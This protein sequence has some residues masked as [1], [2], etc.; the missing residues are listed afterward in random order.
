MLS[1]KQEAQVSAQSDELIGLKK[2]LVQLEGDEHSKMSVL[3]NGKD[4]TKSWIETLKH[5]I[6]VLEG[7]FADLRKPHA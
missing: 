1:G 7:R 3:Q 6:G 5:E 2:L 4:V